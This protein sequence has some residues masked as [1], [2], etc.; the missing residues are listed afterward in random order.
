MITD[1]IITD[2]T[3]S[4]WPDLTEPGVPAEAL[5]KGYHWLA[6]QDDGVVIVGQWSP[7]SRSWILSQIA[8]RLCPK[9]MDHM[10]YLGSCRSPSSSRQ[11]S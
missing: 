9:E 7:D 10:N 5:R 6:N 11:T 2:G 3:G 1:P 4:G 8:E